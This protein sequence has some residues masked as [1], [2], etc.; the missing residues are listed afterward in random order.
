MVFAWAGNKFPPKA[1][2]SLVP[3]KSE[4]FAVASTNTVDK[5]AAAFKK[6]QQAREGEKAMAEYRA[7]QIAEE[8]KTERLRA[9]RLAQQSAPDVAAPA[10]LVGD[11]S[12]PRAPARK[13][14]APRRKPVQRRTTARKRR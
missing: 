2:F 11:V 13:P 14:I 1:F 5:A 9:L 8:K 4:E 6:Q 12:K 3:H 7:A 10:G